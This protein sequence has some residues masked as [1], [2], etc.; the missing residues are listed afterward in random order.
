MRHALVLVLVLLV[1]AAACGGEVTPPR[2][3]ERTIPAR[4][5]AAVAAELAVA[6]AELLPDTAAYRER[7]Q[8]ILSRH[9]VTAG[10]LRSFAGAYGGN[11][12]V[13]QEIYRTTGA[14]FDALFGP[15]S[16]APPS[17]GV[18]PPDDEPAPSAGTQP[19]T[20]AS[21]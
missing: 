7:M 2:P 12:D 9:G 18:A 5:F 3:T 14:R 16:I 6:R 8:Q 13:M 21:R 17:T 10:D 15:S 4:T 20:A 11:E 1:G 19:D